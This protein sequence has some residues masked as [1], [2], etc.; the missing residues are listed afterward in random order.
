MAAFGGRRPWED[1]SAASDDPA[2]PSKKRRIRPGS[3]DV[4]MEFGLELQKA[5]NAV[6]TGNQNSRYT[7]VEVILLSW[8][9]EDPKLPMS[10]EIRELENV[11]TDI[12]HFEVQEWQIPAEDSRNQLQFKIL[13]FLGKS[14]PKHLKIVCYAGHG[15]L[16]N[17][18]TPAWTSLRNS[19][20]ER[21]PTVKWSG[22]QNTP[23]ESRSDV[24]ILLDCCASGVFATDEGNGVT[25]PIAACA[26]NAIANGNGV[27]PFSF[28]HA[29]IAKLRLLAQLTSFNIGYP[30]NAIFTEVQG[31][32]IKDSRFKK[33]HS[34]RPIQEGPYP[35][36]SKSKPDLAKKYM[37]VQ[38]AQNVQQKELT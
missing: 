7:K 23:E 10:L 28:T 9:D 21:C 25:E 1:E 14:D 5:A 22:I 12:S 6:F 27:G 13:E 35:P 29:L 30:Y 24:L 20:K 8:E 37:F 15:R 32:R 16:T 33:A 36:H 3:S 11:F 19:N 31:R 17:H 18:G 26:Y 34:R 4:P 2:P 38:A